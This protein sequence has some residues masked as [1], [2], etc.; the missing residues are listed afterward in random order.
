MKRNIFAYSKSVLMN[1]KKILFVLIFSFLIFSNSEAQLAV[2]NTAPYNNV[3]YLV[4]N[5]L[6][7]SGVQVSNVTYTGSPNAIGYFNGLNSN[8][9]LDSGI[10]LTSGDI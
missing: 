1:M 8:L 5:V 6:L 10:V 2:S 9:N 3:N 7:G 4:Q